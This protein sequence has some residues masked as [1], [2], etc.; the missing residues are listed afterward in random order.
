M[1]Q[2]HNYKKGQ[3]GGRGGAKSGHFV[4]LRVVVWRVVDKSNDKEDKV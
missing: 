4:R 3:G 2:G 1:I